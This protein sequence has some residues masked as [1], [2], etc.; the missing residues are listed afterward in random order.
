MRWHDLA[1]ALELRSSLGMNVFLVLGL[2]LRF[3]AVSIV[4]K[5]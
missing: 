3:K 4:N 1:G 5:L 2:D